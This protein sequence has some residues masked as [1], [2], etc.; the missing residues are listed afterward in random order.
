MPD[1]IYILVPLFLAALA[2]FLGY[3][4]GVKST[5]KKHT[6]GNVTPQN[7]SSDQLARHCFQGINYLLNEQSDQAIDVFIQSVEVNAQTL[8][9]HLALGNLMRQKG[10]VD[11]AIRVHQNLLSRP[12]LNQQQILQAHLELARDYLKAGLFDRAERLFLELVVDAAGEYRQQSLRHL[13]QIYRHEQEWEKAIRAAGLMEKKRFG[14][15]NEEL[16]IEQAHFCCELAERALSRGDSLDV[17]RHLKAALKYNK[18]SV[19]ANILWANQEMAFGHYSKALKRYRMIP[20]QQADYLPEIL[21]S[22]KYCYEQLNDWDGLIKQYRNWFDAY[23]GNSI[24][25]ALSDVIRQKEGNRQAIIFLAEN[26]KT[27]PSIKGLHSFLDIHMENLEA[28]HGGLMGGDVLKDS[29]VKENLLLL[30]SI[31]NSMLKN[32]PS[33]CCTQCGFKSVKLHWLCP[34]CENWETVKLI[35]GVTGE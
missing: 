15:G 30:K 34:Q 35:R 31:L 9:T 11:R 3:R 17:R 23:P 21:E 22:V 1:I 13:V 26:L 32:K 19:R 28:S 12:N 14:R 6:Q 4:Y 33:Y 5:H 8:E 16:A 24:L 7:A 20:Q 25:K 18:N 29:R 2:W 27:L 10:E